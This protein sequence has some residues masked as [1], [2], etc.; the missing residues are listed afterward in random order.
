MLIAWNTSLGSPL[1]C[2]N[3]KD[4]T[5]VQLLDIE[6]RLL[7][8]Q[9]TKSTHTI[10]PEVYEFSKDKLK[11]NSPQPCT[12]HGPLTGKLE[13]D[14]VTVGA[15]LAMTLWLYVVPLCHYTSVSG[16]AIAASAIFPMLGFVFGIQFCT[17]SLLSGKAM[18]TRIRSRLSKTWEEVFQE[19]SIEDAIL[20]GMIC[21]FFNTNRHIAQHKKIDLTALTPSQ[22]Y[23]ICKYKNSSVTE[24]CNNDQLVSRYDEPASSFSMAP[25]VPVKVP[26]TNLEYVHA[27]MLNLLSKNTTNT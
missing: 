7:S 19:R 4:L 25:Y 3:W 18:A 2:F 14:Q 11:S 21:Q 24:L 22:A 9:L 20:V 12:F 8:V 15:A 1:H 26:T 16:W 10:S 17:Y 6:K 23:D 27:E 13:E 5:V